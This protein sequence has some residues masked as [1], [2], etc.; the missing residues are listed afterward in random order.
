MV[1]DPIV[2]DARH[3]RYADASAFDRKAE[4]TAHYMFAVG[5]SANVST[6]V[7]YVGSQ[8]ERFLN[9]DNGSYARLSDM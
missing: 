2:H 6:V 4:D 9:S 3:A 8:M 1:R 5:H 7:R